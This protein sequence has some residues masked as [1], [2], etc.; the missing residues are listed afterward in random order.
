MHNIFSKLISPGQ[1]FLLF[2]FPLASF[3]F[4]KHVD[5][6]RI[7][8]AIYFFLLPIV[9]LFVSPELLKVKHKNSLYA[10][11]VRWIILL[12]IFSIMMA[13]IF[14][15]QDPALGYRIT[16]YYMTIIYFF[17]LKR[18]KPDVQY[19]ETM[20]WS[21]CIIYLLVWGYALLASP[22]I[23][24]G[25]RG[26]EIDTSRGVARFVI[27]GKDAVILAFFIAV[28]KFVET[29]RKYGSLFFPFFFL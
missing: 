12:I 20:I 18:I 21:F 4:Y 2:F 27:T 14:W 19:I 3:Y 7:S 10:G 26:G 29:K 8:K 9:V 24:F 23:T 17:V 11:Y 16:A 1:K 25:A 22:Q 28:S 5:L 13:F 6:M 15:G